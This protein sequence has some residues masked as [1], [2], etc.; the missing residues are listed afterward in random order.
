[1][2]RSSHKCR[3]NING[4]VFVMDTDCVLLEVGTEIFL[5]RGADKSFARTGREQAAPVK[6]MIGRGMD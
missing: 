5:Y 4:Y 2:V 6:S 3:N 1:M